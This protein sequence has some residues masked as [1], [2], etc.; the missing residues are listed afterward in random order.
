MPAPAACLKLLIEGPLFE[1]S[2]DLRIGA[3][4]LAIASGVCYRSIANLRSKVSTIC[5]E[6]VA[7]EL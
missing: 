1:A 4:G 7:S 2:Q 6:K 5:L 3:L